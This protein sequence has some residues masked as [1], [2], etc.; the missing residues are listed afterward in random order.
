LAYTLAEEAGLTSY[1]RNLYVDLYQSDSL[2]QLR[3]VWDYC[4]RV[5]AK[6]S[7]HF[8]KL[9]ELKNQLKEQWHGETVRVLNQEMAPLINRP[10]IWFEKL[11]S[12]EAHLDAYMHSR[13]TSAGAMA[14]AL[15]LSS[16][17]DA[18]Q[19]LYNAQSYYK[20]V[21]STTLTR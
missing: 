15:G 14:A 4:N 11:K 18:N 16:E 8:R 1:W 6:G 13:A 7:P 19:A 9:E 12:P 17:D 21:S 3:E 2:E 20:S 10:F 5:A